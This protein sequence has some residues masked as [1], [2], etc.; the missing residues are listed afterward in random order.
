M[1]GIIAILRRELLSFFVSPVAY[2]VVTGFLLLGAYFFFNL[3]GIYNVVLQR[4]QMMPYGMGQSVPNL[5]QFVVENYFQTMLL[6][7]VFLVPLLTMRLIAEEKKSG[8]FELL[9]TSPL[10][11]EQIVIGK[12]LGVGTI[13]FVMLGLSFGFP[14][15]L[16]MFA[17]PEFLPML[18][19]FLGV[20]LAG[21][22]FVSVGMAVSSFASS[23][24]VAGV[25]SMVVLLLLYV[26]HSPAES[27]GG[28]A[29]A[30][31][32]YLSPLLQAQQMIKG[33]MPLD[34]LVYFGSLITLGLVIS[35]RALGSQ[36]WR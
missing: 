22:S 19:G 6:I 15:I 16:T 34:G 35:Q 17:N 14:L 12:F 31:L 36:R 30:V 29:G 2:F 20:F 13:L 4:I 27:L 3:L 23:Q 1:K 32:E 9:A 25:T 10:S 11:I 8:T 21:L 33:V 28:S 24:V 26:I 5:N 7:L 18:I